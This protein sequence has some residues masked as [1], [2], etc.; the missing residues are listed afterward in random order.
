LRWLYCHP[1]LCL[2]VCQTRRRLGAG[3]GLRESGQLLA[4]RGEAPAI[5][6][7]AQVRQPDRH[8]AQPFRPLSVAKPRRALIC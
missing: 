7:I 5:R 3:F 8:R 6:R 2:S 4:C 1:G